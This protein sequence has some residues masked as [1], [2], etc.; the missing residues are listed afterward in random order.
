MKGENG[1]VVQSVLRA[2]D[3]LCYFQ[4]NE[5]LGISEISRMIGLGKS[6][7]YALP[8]FSGAVAYKQKIQAG[9]PQL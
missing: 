3:I 7:V 2:L 8:P 9:N 6:T 1:T 4:D 5:E